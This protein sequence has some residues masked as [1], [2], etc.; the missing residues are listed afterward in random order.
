MVCCGEEKYGRKKRRMI[1]TTK[2]VT[3]AEFEEEKAGGSRRGGQKSI[4]YRDLM[5]V[6]PC[7]LAFIFFAFSNKSFALVVLIELLVYR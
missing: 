4:H 3:E 6:G 2:T 5:F 7:R 1:N